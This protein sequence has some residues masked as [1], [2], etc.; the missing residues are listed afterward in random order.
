MLARVI[1]FPRPEDLPIIGQGFA[2]LTGSGVFQNA[3]GS[4]DGYQVGLQP[5]L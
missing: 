4:I 2:D 1:A 5:V 3:V